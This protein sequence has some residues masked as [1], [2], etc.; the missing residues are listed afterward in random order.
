MGGGKEFVLYSKLIYFDLK[1]LLIAMAITPI[2]NIGMILHELIL[3]FEI[4]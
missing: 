4:K 2:Y 3:V 1:T